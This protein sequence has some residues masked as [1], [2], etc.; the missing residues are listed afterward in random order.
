LSTPSSVLQLKLGIGYKVEAFLVRTNSSSEFM[1]ILMS[2]VSFDTTIVY[3][4]RK[5]LSG[6]RSFL[7]SIDYPST[8]ACYGLT[9][10]PYSARVSP[11][12]VR[13]IPAAQLQICDYLHHTL[14]YH[15]RSFTKQSIHNSQIW[16]WA[17]PPG[18]DS[19]RTFEPDLI[20]PVP[21]YAIVNGQLFP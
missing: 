17:V 10:L 9:L 13:G 19:Q 14:Q 3:R 20:N 12:I 18:V 15:I 21:G 5:D 1:T 6:S 7:N 4:G 16:S 8:I 2:V 11:A